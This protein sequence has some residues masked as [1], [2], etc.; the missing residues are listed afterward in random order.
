MN[1][2]SFCTA[3]LSFDNWSNRLGFPRSHSSS[4][5]CLNGVSFVIQV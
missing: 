4:T 3:I 2:F 1:R 5:S